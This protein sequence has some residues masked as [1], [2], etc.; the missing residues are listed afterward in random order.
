MGH[1]RAHALP[2]ILFELLW[3]MG[4]RRS[5]FIQWLPTQMQSHR[6]RSE[7]KKRYDLVL[8]FSTSCEELSSHFLFRFL[9]ELETDEKA[10]AQPSK[11]SLCRLY[12]YWGRKVFRRILLLDL[13]TLHPIYFDFMIFIFFWLDCFTP[14]SNSDFHRR[15][16]RIL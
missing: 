12:C 3:L 4:N 7:N 15:Q 2:A 5:S 10:T 6:S 9:E 16:W 13:R 8:F 14:L 1:F 11:P